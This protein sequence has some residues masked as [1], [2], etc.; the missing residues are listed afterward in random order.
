[1]TQTKIFLLALTS[2]VLISCSCSEKS[3]LGDLTKAAGDIVSEGGEA[4]E[5][6]KEA[7]SKL[8]EDSM[9]K[10][11]DMAGDSMDKAKDMAAGSMD[12]VKKMGSEIEGKLGEF[13]STNLPNGMKLN[14]PALGVENKLI[15]SL[16]E[17]DLPNGN[18]WFDFDRL[19]FAS[20][21]SNLSED[22]KEQTLNIAKIMKAYPA[23][24]LKVGGYTDNTGSDEVNNRISAARASAVMSAIVAE[25]IDASRL[26]AEGFGNTHP[27]ASNDTAEGR[28]KNRRISLKVLE[29]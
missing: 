18:E 21:S 5:S 29:K 4:L 26:S 24:K 6:A 25:G 15:Q 12:K 9:D 14:I 11:K 1:M 20:G 17:K 19:N 13:L 28:E 23:L 16:S 10:A 2:V 3:K 7:T 8:A 27:V 22:S